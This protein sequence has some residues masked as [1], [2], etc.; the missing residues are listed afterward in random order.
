METSKLG[1]FIEQRLQENSALSRLSDR[2]RRLVQELVFGVV[3]QRQLLDFWITEKTRG[4]TQ[5][6]L[7]QNILRLGIYQVICLDR[8]PHHAAVHETLTAARAVGVRHE[9]G[10]LN[11]VLRACARDQENIRGQWKKL[12]KSDPATGWSLPGWLVR[13]WETRW[14]GQDI[15]ETAIRLADD[16]TVGDPSLTDTKESETDPVPWMCGWVNT[17]PVTFARRNSLRTDAPTL[18]S[19]WH[20]E[21]VIHRPVHR[22]W[23][24]PGQVYEISGPSAIHSLKSFQDGA[25]YLQDPSTLLAPS[26]LNPTHGQRVLDLCAAPGGKTTVMAQSMGNEGEI[27]AVDLDATRLLRVQ[28]NCQRL[29]ITCCRIMDLAAFHSLRESKAQ[30]FDRILVD[31]PCSNTGVL[32]R[33]VELRW[34]LTPG[35]IERLAKEQLSL[36]AQASNWLAPDGVLV[37]STCSLEEEENESVVKDFLAGHPDYQLIRERTL[38]PFKDGVDGAYV[39]EL[40]RH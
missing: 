16:F 28:E 40:Q 14:G 20:A 27:F 6:P 8:I 18:E 17:P 13:R 32:R 15:G 36:L 12:R 2:D 19:M 7:I 35:E 4:K 26:W 9:I 24:A 29:G 33:R 23:L 5:K 37:Y 39:A 1:V 3:R 34:R 25:F 10:F 22:D 11:A 31:A 38:V 21:G 30:N